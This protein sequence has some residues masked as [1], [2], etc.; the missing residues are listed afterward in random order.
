VFEKGKRSKP[1]PPAISRSAWDT[2]PR[3]ETVLVP[4]KLCNLPP[5]P[6]AAGRLLA[7][8]EADGD[9]TGV[10]SVVGGDPAL[11]AEVLFLANSSLFG[12]P[13]RIQSLRHA[14]AVLG[15]SCIRQLATTLALRA[16]RGAGPFV[17][18][19][20]RHS[21]ACAVI[22]EKFAP[23][24]GCVA[25]HGYTAGLMHDIGR[26][27]FLRSYP[28][29]IGAVLA[30]GYSDGDEFLAAERTAMNASHGEA[31]AWLIEYWTLPP[32]FSEI[33]ARHH[34][35]FQES[36]SPLLTLIKLACRLADAAGY[37]AVRYRTG[38]GYDDV[39]QSDLPSL[40]GQFFPDEQAIRDEVESRLAAFE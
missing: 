9:V 30:A 25:E 29:E 18:P 22:A 24:F 37:A 6:P 11:A 1:E 40:A 31:G 14:V 28:S 10:A 36:D 13:A 16:L 17:R 2:G 15:I 26:L 4:I 7:C 34:D 12:F 19:C 5:F 32:A 21:L 20:W 27:G 8:S 23:L 38:P 3:E 35:P 39:L 33:C